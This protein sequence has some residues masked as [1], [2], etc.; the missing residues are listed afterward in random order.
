MHKWV[1]LV[2]RRQY[3]IIYTQANTQKFPTTVSLGE[4]TDEEFNVESSKIKV[5]YWAVC[6]E[7]H[8]NGSFHYH[9]RVK[10]TGTKK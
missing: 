3:L 4:V 5:D 7:P 2:E 10:L 8:E 1:T 9:C 6:K